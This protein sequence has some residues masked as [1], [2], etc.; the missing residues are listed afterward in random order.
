MYCTLIK[1]VNISKSEKLFKIGT[2]KETNYIAIGGSNGFIQI[3]DLDVSADTKKEKGSQ[4]SFNQSLKYHSDDISLLTWN[5]N[6]NKLTTCDKSGV[7]VVWKFVDNKWETEMINNREQSIVTDIKWNRQGQY[8]CFIYE[9][10]HAIVGTVD[11]NR[12]WGNDIRNS[13]YLIEWSPDG[14]ILLLASRNQDITILTS[15][16]QQLGVIEID[17]K[18]KNIDIASICWW[19]KYIDENKIITLQ[20]HLMLAFVNGDILLYDD[21]N[22]MNPFYI[23]TNLKQITKAEWNINGDALLFVALLMKEILKVVYLY[24]IQKENF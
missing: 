4:I 13:L 1:K 10:G 15:S 14:T 18:L 23:K 5:D 16:G 2:N 21:E 20:K 19:S 9:D 22:D 24:I 12:S 7:I 8:L 6:Y 17:E 11:G 3:V